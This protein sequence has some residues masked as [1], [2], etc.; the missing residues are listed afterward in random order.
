MTRRHRLDSSRR[1]TLVAT[2]SVAAAAVLLPAQF[3]QAQAAK[4]VTLITPYQQSVTTNEMLKTLADLGGKK[5]WKVNVIDTKGDFGQMASRME[6]A[7]AAKTDAI[8]IVSADPN[9]VKTQI[10]G[11][12]DKGI[13]VFGCDS[14]YIPGMVMNA[15]SD[16]AAMSASITGFLM[17]SIG[18]K[19]SL[20]VFTHRPHPGVLKRTQELDALLKKSPDVKVRSELH[21]QVPGPIESARTQ[22]ENLLL[23]NPGKGSIT[24]VWAAWDEPAIGA[25]Q[26]IQAAGR[27]EIV[28]TGI[29]GTSQ[30]VDLIKK[31]SPLIATMKQNF[32]GMADLVITQIDATFKGQKPT[33]TEMF[34]PAMLVTK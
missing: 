22:M 32:P 9:Q 25:T 19:G 23:A 7:V 27:T 1:R 3:A 10:K 12:A 24:A 20:V 14:G 33:A 29:D 30:A 31:G 6:D 21:V 28:V 34:A 8:V 17:K 2:L 16:N 26:A 4:T 11:A 15:T 13:P 18:N 5:G